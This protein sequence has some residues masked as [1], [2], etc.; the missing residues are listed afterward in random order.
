MSHMSDINLFVTMLIEARNVQTLVTGGSLV[1]SAMAIASSVHVLILITLSASVPAS[2]WS[3]VSAYIGPL[4]NLRVL[5]LTVGM[6]PRGSYI[7][8]GVTARRWYLPHLHQLDIAVGSTP[9][10]FVSE[11]APL[12]ASSDLPMLQVLCLLLY[13]CD[14]PITRGG[15][16]LGQFLARHPLHELALSLCGEED[17]HDFMP[18]CLPQARTP[19]LRVPYFHAAITL[20]LPRSVRTLHVEEMDIEL[21]WPGCDVLIERDTGLKIVTT[22]YGWGTSDHEVTSWADY[23]RLADLD[24]YQEA[25]RSRRLRYAC[26]LAAKGIRL[27]DP[28]GKVLADYFKN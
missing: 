27:Q 18:T 19:Y 20:H 16:A 25:S 1:V 10:L 24:E 22:S 13:Q 12:L 17:I 3:S 4:L 26:L 21:S 23:W 15:A 5:T 2:D 7:P 28:D 8:S 6:G 11:L 14:P 9:S